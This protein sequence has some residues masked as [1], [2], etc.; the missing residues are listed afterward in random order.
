MAQ[1]GIDE[2][3]KNVRYI[4]KNLSK[5]QIA[6]LLASLFEIEELPEIIVLNRGEKSIKGFAK[7][8]KKIFMFNIAFIVIRDKKIMRVVLAFGK[9]A[10]LKCNEVIMETN[11]Q[12]IDVFLADN[13]Q[14]LFSVYF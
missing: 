12:E 8:S 4:I 9:Q 2:W 6:E 13:K 11:E 7:F 5:K 14:Y 3:K 10:L 1:E